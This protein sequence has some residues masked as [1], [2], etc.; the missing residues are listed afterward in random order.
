MYSYVVW[1]L[2][3]YDHSSCDNLDEQVRKGGAVAAD[4][5]EGANVAVLQQRIRRRLSR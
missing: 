4:E 2:L 5:D 3:E 1:T